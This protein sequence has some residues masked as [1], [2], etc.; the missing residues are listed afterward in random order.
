MIVWALQRNQSDTQRL[1]QPYY[2]TNTHSRE[3]SQTILLVELKKNAGK[4]EAGGWK[5]G[6]KHSP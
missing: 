2:D 4:K 5:W 6:M 1:V 3:E